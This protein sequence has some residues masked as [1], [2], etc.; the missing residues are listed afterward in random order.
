MDSS[1]SAGYSHV[2]QLLDAELMRAVR[3]RGLAA[4][5]LQPTLVYGPKSG[6]WTHDV[7]DTLRY[8]TVVLPGQGEGTCNAVY[9]DDVVSAMILAAQT[10]AAIG[11]SYLVS[12]PPVTWAEFY[13]A[14]AATLGT[15]GPV[16]L[17]PDVIVAENRRLR[18][19]LRLVAQPGRVARL[20]VRA[21]PGRAAM[22]MAMKAMPS[23]MRLAMSDRFFGPRSRQRGYVHMPDVGRMRWMESK[24]TVTSA[25]ARRDL[26][27]RPE[28]DLAAGMVPTSEYLRTSYAKG[29]EWLG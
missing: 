20:A 9:V 24:S 15:P 8:G 18:K 16:F 27:Y 11:Q 28:F 25:K 12:G 14:M 13:N 23:K 21:G 6:P 7:A 10:A 3:E 1:A 22:R 4:T 29:T 19:V 26:G 2:K 17:P 5:I